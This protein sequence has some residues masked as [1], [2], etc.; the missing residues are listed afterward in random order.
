MCVYI[1]NTTIH[2]C[3]FIYTYIHLQKHAAERLPSQHFAHATVDSCSMRAK[4]YR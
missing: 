4:E 1:Y 3:K 2:L